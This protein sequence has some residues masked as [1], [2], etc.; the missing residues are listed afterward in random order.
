MSTQTTDGAEADMTGGPGQVRIEPWSEDDLD[1]R[2]KAAEMG[3]TE[4]EYAFYA[5]VAQTVPRRSCSAA[6]CS[7][8]SP[9]DLVN[10]VQD[11]PVDWW[12]RKQDQALVRAVKRLLAAGKAASPR[13]PGLP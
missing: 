8:R 7:G 1:L 12:I 5:A 13:R 6:E 10:E 3:L 9:L 2:G 11:L 4:D